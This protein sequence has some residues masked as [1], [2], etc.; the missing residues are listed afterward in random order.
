MI[1]LA[2]L[3]PSFTEALPPRSISTLD[4]SELYILRAITI[5]LKNTGYRGF[6]I[7]L[8]LHETEHGHNIRL[9]EP[10]GRQHHKM[11]SESV[12]HGERFP[13]LH[14]SQGRAS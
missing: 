2:V 8:E 7:K 4:L 3:D 10:R 11:S 9:C 5:H 1:N 13:K 6:A 12:E 14:S